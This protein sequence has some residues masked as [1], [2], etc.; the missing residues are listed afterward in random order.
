M[1]QFIT[2]FRFSLLALL[3]ATSANIALATS[4]DLDVSK[5]ED[6]HVPNSRK[7]LRA[8][9][10]GTCSDR[11]TL[12][13]DTL[14]SA[15]VLNE[16]CTVNQPFFNAIALIIRANDTEHMKEYAHEA[17]LKL[18][19]DSV[20]HGVSS[21]LNMTLEKIKDAYANDSDGKRI[22]SLLQNLKRVS[23]MHTFIRKINST[24]DALND[25]YTNNGSEVDAEK[26][27][28][29]LKHAVLKNVEEFK[30]RMQEQSKGFEVAENL[31]GIRQRL[32]R[33]IKEMNDTHRTEPEYGD[34]LKILQE[35]KQVFDDANIGAHFDEAL[36]KLKALFEDSGPAEGL[37]RIMSSM[38]RALQ[39]N[40][41]LKQMKTMLESVKSAYETGDMKALESIAQKLK[42]SISCDSCKRLDRTKEALKSL[43][44]CRESLNEEL[45]LGIMHEE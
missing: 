14:S 7:H 19:N 32:V 21:R 5:S 16:E 15:R 33:S 45:L 1:I 30:S 39:M 25:A 22:E 9:P 6:I 40:Q 42:N 11:E 13:G 26:V 43:N 28:D 4:S 17:H 10:Q 3:L 12:L 8:K 44:K 35:A 37:D 34:I 41:M 38:K 29:E 24:V 20:A 31:C 2:S 27:A 18:R 36:E 23:S